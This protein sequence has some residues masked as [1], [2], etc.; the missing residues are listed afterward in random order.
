MSGSE[1]LGAKAVQLDCLWRSAFNLESG[2]KGTVGYLSEWRGL[3]GVSLEK[4]IVVWSPVPGP[5]S[6]LPKNFQSS[7]GGGTVADQVKCVG[8][9]EHFEYGGEASD[10]IRIS[11]YMSKDNQARIRYKLARPLLNTSLKVDYAII[12]FDEDSK[13]WYS[14]V[15]VDGGPSDAQINTRDGALQLFMAFEATPISEAL[16]INVYRLEF[17]MIPGEATT[18]LELASGP[19]HRYVSEWK[20][21]E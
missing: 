9:I 15:E 8:V 11:A 1:T 13:S 12:G 20:G 10:P 17:E 18:R 7:S 16:N 14:S 4:D 19:V 5:Q 6:P 2:K 21:E 3:G